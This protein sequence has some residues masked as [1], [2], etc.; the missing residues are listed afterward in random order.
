MSKRASAGKP[1][2]QR[3]DSI[4]R[5]ASLIED[6]I[7]GSTTISASSTSS[8]T[9]TNVSV[10]ESVSTKTSI[11][12]YENGVS[13]LESLAMPGYLS[14]KE[15]N[16]LLL[17][18][19]GQVQ[20]LE[21]NQSATGDKTSITV[22]IDRSEVTK[23]KSKYDNQLEDWK[24][25]CGNKDKEIAA[26]KAEIT[27]L[28][29]EIKRLKES[30]DKKDGTI[31][32]RDLTIEGL[33]AEISKLQSNLSKFQNQKE[34]YEFQIMRL[35]REISFLTGEINTMTSAFATE[36]DRSNDLG[37][38]LASMEKELKFK[39]DVLGNELVSERGKTS[40]DITSMDTRIQGEYANRLKAELK[41]LRKVYE[42]HM[43]ESEET[44][45]MNYKTKISDLEVKLSVQM[46]A[47]RP[48]EDAI[49][50]KKELEKY[51]KKI[52]ELDSNNQDLRMK[53][54]KLAVELRD[55][56]AGFQAKMTAKEIEMSHLSR[57]SAEYKRL[58][59]EIRSKVLVEASEVKVYNRLITPEV[60]RI[61]RSVKQHSSSSKRTLQF[62]G[63]DGSS[64]SSSDEETSKLAE[65]AMGNK[66]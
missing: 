63:K 35:Q 37:K 9:S 40:I 45:E 47:A 43:K 5:S 24:N 53:W 55:Q 7:D 4:P 30:N 22:D 29:A 66:N 62:S 17:K 39:I 51:K 13:P 41:L 65:K 8:V 12:S 28:K 18:Y 31:K 38:R 27:K 57:Q 14:L 52:E 34:I 1:Q 16:T 11:Y 26:L 44:L 36:Q 64:S 15:L 59:E 42:K 56:E 50:L 20:D 58:Y 6:D 10:A 3:K 60:D 54:S 46:N 21:M 32:E 49:E 33:R 23:L 61:G 2:N 19:I 48:A 25:Q